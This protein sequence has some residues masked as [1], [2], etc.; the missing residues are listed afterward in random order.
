VRL[1][2]AAIQLV[3]VHLSVKEW[4]AYPGGWPGQIVLGSLYS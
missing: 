1:D 2:M 3:N 4:L